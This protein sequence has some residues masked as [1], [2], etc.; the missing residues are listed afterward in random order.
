MG[1]SLTRAPVPFAKKPWVR[2]I[3]RE[4]EL[5]LI[6][7]PM[8][9]FVIIFSY[10]PMWGVL[11]GFTDY[12]PGKSFLDLQFV[13]LKYIR[14]FI[15]SPDFKQIL[16]NT[17][18]M[19]GLGIAIGFPAPI[20]LALLLNELR[21]NAFKRTV[22]TIS[23]LPHFVSWPVIASIIVTILGSEGSIN[24]FLIS[25]QFIERPIQ[26]LGRGEFFWAIF[27]AANLWKGIGWSTIIYLSNIAGVDTE[28]YDAGAIDGL[29]RF[30]MMRSITIP[31][32]MPTIILLFILG[33]GGILNAGFE[34][35]L[36]LGN[37]MTREYHE[38]IDTYVYRYGVQMGRFTYGIAVG[39]FKSIIGLA[40]VIITNRVARKTVGMSIF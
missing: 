27:T 20:I 38:V 7:I 10:I 8:I 21:S 17:L 26:F 36:L 13:G 30:G 9:I 18:A 22:Q 33:L 16:R 37:S 1:D 4:R 12:V 24:K 35:Q 5:W 29:G 2:R 15:D 40:L 3:Y 11:L 25:S 31:G 23:Y 39:F 19:S 32:I 6:C 34:Q 28:L 14:Q